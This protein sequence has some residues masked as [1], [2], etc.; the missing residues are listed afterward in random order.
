MRRSIRSAALAATLAAAGPAAAGGFFDDFDTLDGKRWFVSDGWTN[1]PHQNCIWTRAALDVADGALTL[2]LKRETTTS[3]DGNATRPY[4][5]AEIQTRQTY[6][7][8][9][10]EARIKA[11]GGSGLNSAFFTYTGEPA[12]DEIDVEILG[13]DT[14]RFD[15]N[16][17]SDGKGEN[18]ETV[19]VPQPADEAMIDYAF[20]WTPGRLRWYVNG[21]LKREVVRADVPDAEQKVF[22]SLWNG[23]K[24]MSG[25]LGPQDD[26][27]E[28]RTMVVDHVGFTPMGERCLFAGSLSCSAAWAGW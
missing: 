12:H 26:T 2:T 6:G 19:A 11:A 8:G 9:L 4:S 22:F 18:Q 20:E 27:I 3:G 7:H 23:G 16:Y 17:Y 14:T 1:G 25:W 24:G 21:V 13:R 5:C 15:A 28:V 10:F